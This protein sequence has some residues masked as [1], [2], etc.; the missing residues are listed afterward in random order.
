VN[1][2]VLSQTIGSQIVREGVF[3][4]S[5]VLKDG[6]DSLFSPGFDS[7]FCIGN[8]YGLCLW[9]LMNRL[10]LLSHPSLADWLPLSYQGVP[11]NALQY[12]LRKLHFRELPI[13]WTQKSTQSRNTV[14]EEVLQALGESHGLDWNLEVKKYFDLKVQE[15][16]LLK[17]PYQ[18]SLVTEV[19]LLRNQIP[20]ICHAV[21]DLVQSRISHF[22]TSSLLFTRLPLHDYGIVFPM[23]L[24]YEK[25]GYSQ[26]L[27]YLPD[28]KWCLF[29]QSS[30]DFSQIFYVFLSLLVELEYLDLRV[31]S[32]L[33]ILEEQIRV[34]SWAE[35][36]LGSV[37]RDTREEV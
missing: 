9:Q 13:H 33:K 20:Y 18:D 11:Q 15:D 22:H 35:V 3:E 36:R 24:V 2:F 26:H 23:G 10:Q 17:I 8:F 25:S 12:L 32:Y 34:S 27:F 1:T 5:I 6:E 19:I 7:R 30:E 14:H 37:N 31:E 16:R 21:S 4:W 29:I 28:V